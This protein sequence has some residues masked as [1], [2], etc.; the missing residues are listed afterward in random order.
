MAKDKIK[1]PITLGDGK[2]FENKNAQ[3]Y[4]KKYGLNCHFDINSYEYSNSDI[5]DWYRVKKNGKK[6]KYKR[7]QKKW[8]EDNN[9]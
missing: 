6:Y 9:G 8:E 4:I 7:S 1:G 5:D 3:K 2:F